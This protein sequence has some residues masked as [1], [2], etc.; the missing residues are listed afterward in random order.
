MSGATLDSY[1]LLVLSDLHVLSEDHEQSH[2][3]VSLTLFLALDLRLSGAVSR[4]LVSELQHVV[5][6]TTPLVETV[7]SFLRIF[8]FVL[9]FVSQVNV[10][11]L[12]TTVKGIGEKRQRAN[13]FAHTSAHPSCPAA[14]T[15][16]L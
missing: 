1:F 8:A 9:Q 7:L 6:L 2:V 10:L 3:R 15:G 5:A 16:L 4:I 12:V 14:S 11:S 13:I